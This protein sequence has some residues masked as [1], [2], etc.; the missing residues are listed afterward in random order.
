VD[1]QQAIGTI[2]SAYTAIDLPLPTIVF[3]TNP[4][5][6]LTDYV[7]KWNQEEYGEDLSRRFDRLI[8]SDLENPIE[9]QIGFE[10]HKKL[11]EELNQ[12]L[13]NLYFESGSFEL[14]RWLGICPKI[15][16]VY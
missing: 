13:T 11:T 7:S 10:L 15:F 9:A 3:C 4:Q 1:R 5:A 8:W 12:Y 2:K 16:V 6:A 14:I